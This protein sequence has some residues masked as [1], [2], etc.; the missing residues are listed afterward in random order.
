MPPISSLCAGIRPTLYMEDLTSA[1][2]A[3]A[4]NAST[5]RRRPPGG[6]AHEAWRRSWCDCSVLRLFCGDLAFH[7]G[8]HRRHAPPHLFLG[9][10]FLVRGDEPLVAGRVL[11]G[12]AAVAVEGVVRLFDRCRAGCERLL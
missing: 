7:R 2:A 3:T 10:V 12:G 1:E 11:H 8:L 5:I 6:A 4:Y 9:W